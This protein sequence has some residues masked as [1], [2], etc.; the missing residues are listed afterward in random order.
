MRTISKNFGAEPTTYHIP[1]DVATTNLDT[2]RK[3]ILNKSHNSM[4]VVAE[5]RQWIY[6]SGI[7]LGPLEQKGGSALHQMGSNRERVLDGDTMDLPMISQSGLR[8]YSTGDV[9]SRS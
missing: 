6:F 4:H 5:T 8:G 2:K 3:P 9:N 1:P 7:I